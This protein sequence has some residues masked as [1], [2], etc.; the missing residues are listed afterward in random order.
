MKGFF[1]AKE[2][3]WL[4]ILPFIAGL[5]F[6]WLD[7]NISGILLCLISVFILYF[8]RQPYRVAIPKEA[9]IYAPAD[10]RIIQIREEY[11][12]S[13]FKELVYKISIFMSLSN[14]HITYAPINGRIDY[15]QY[16]PGRFIRADKISEGTEETNENN[17]IGISNGNRHVAIRQVAG[18]IARR[19]VCDIKIGDRLVAGKR[20]GMIK[21]GSRIDVYLPKDWQVSVSKGERTRA[22]RTVLAQRPGSEKSKI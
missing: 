22:G 11:E 20:I 6:L 21:F 5:F 18:C 14:V 10:G 8:F 3:L 1:I 2:G 7:L 12:N 17:F 4:G 19:I 9:I 15:L 13:F 16:K